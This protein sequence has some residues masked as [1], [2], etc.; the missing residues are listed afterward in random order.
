[1]PRPAG[2][3]HVELQQ[4]TTGL[5]RDLVAA[6]GIT[7][8]QPARWK[9]EGQLMR[10]PFDPLRCHPNVERDVTLAEALI[11][12][13]AHAYTTDRRLSEVAAD[14]VAGRLHFDRDHS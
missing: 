1:M 12:L 13:R 6:V 3:D 8:V 10:Q 7:D 14:V 2:V 11:R 9:L 5:D 4:P